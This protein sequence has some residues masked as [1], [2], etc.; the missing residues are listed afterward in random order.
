MA[1][2]VTITNHNMDSIKRISGIIINSIEDV[3]DRVIFAGLEDSVHA[4]KVSHREFPPSP[5]QVCLIFSFLISLFFLLFLKLPW[6]LPVSLRVMFSASFPPPDSQ[7]KD[8]TIHLS[9][10]T[11][12]LT[13]SHLSPFL[14]LSLFHT[15]THPL[16][17]PCHR[18]TQTRPPRCL[19][20]LLSPK[21]NTPWPM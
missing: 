21:K 8:T 6:F 14:K 10:K 19:P 18:L 7:N 3:L 2:L 4:P 12:F 20:L 17:S 9:L 15:H 13:H 5:S 16:P 11:S 1:D